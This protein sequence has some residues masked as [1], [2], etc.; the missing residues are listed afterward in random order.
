LAIQLI[1]SW[2]THQLLVFVEP[3]YREDIKAHMP[4]SAALFCA[5]LL[6]VAA[7]GGGSSGSGGVSGASS[8]TIVF[9]TQ[10]LGTEGDAT[11]KAVAAFQQANPSIKV[12]ILNL[13]PTANTAYQQLTQRFISGSSTPDVATS[14]V[15][16]P[17]T[18]A[19]SGWI[20]P[21]DGFNPN[22]ANF[23]PGQVQAGTYNGKLYGLPWF[24]NAEGVYYRTDLTPT[25]PKTP[26]DLTNM[27]KAAGSKDPN[28]KVGLAYEGAKYEGVVT[29]FLNFAGG[30]GG[31][32]DLKHLNSSQNVQALNYMK[33]A[34]YND[35]ISPQ[36]VTSWQESD[37]QAAY[38]GGQAAFA[39]N[40]PYVYQLAEA[41]N[42]NLKG[43]VG[44]IP[45]PAGTNTPKAA[46][47]GD[48]LVINSKSQL[49]PAAWKFVQ[50]LNSDSI[51]IDRA[52]TAGDPPAVKSA[53]NQSLY[54]QA[55]YYQAQKPVFDVATPR[56][57]T[58]LYP[59]VSDVLQ[60]QLNAALS[61]QISAQ[62]ALNSAQSQINS[63]L[64]GGG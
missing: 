44:W 59:R 36:S 24:I 42:S 39:M 54:S 12:Q 19:K 57:V 13:S 10:G 58:P 28:V 56:P 64:S 15:I 63:I 31:S 46:L 47:G 55:A 32:L 29:S 30:F 35:K 2:S 48:A 14:D 60:T 18:F 8:G 4:R 23:F 5:G 9:A 3:F 43:K 45:F 22:T 27:A 51:Q 41:S 11:N 53:Y 52:V 40:W 38:L 21:L 7:C 1:S 16:W 20:M 34:I 37:V 25:A 49:A 17:A 50:F 62:D 61:N 26:Q 33:N 6:V